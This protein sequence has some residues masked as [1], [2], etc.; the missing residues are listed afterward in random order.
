MTPPLDTASPSSRHAEAEPDILASMREDLTDWR[1]WM[2]RAVVLLYAVLAGLAVVLFTWVSDGA[3]DG[4]DH[5]RRWSPWAPLVW[6][7]CCTALLVWLTRRFAPGAAG[8]GI[9]QVMAA[10]A[11][12]VT[13]EHRGLFVSLRLSAEKLLLVSGGLLGGL[14]IGR[15]GPSVQIAAG[16]MQHAQR[17][18]PQRSPLHH[19]GLLVAGGAAGIAAAFNAPL[20]GVMFAIE[21]M[22]RK[23]E[24]RTSG[25]LIA[26]IVLAG[27]VAVSVF[28]NASYFGRLRVEPLTWAHLWPGLLTA[29]AC[30]LMGGVFSRLLQ[31]SLLGG[32]DRFSR[33]RARYPVRFAFACGLVIAVMGWVS[34]GATDGSGYSYTRRLVEGELDLPVL[35]V[36]LRIVATWLAVWSGV[37]GGIFAPSLAIGAGIGSDIA[38]LAGPDQ[39]AAVMIAIGMTAFLAAVTQAPITAFIIV[40]EMVD[41]HAMVLSLMAAALL[42][43]LMSRWISVPIYHR[44]AQAQLRRLPD[45][46][47]PTPGAAATSASS[48][49]TN[50]S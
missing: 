26:A 32:Q 13:P 36:T 30:G 29:V 49:A 31:R 16:V 19:D 33:W 35:Y 46:P 18:L 43:S 25:L 24:Q 28:G 50:A 10:L 3:I 12:Q 22:T 38:Q 27:L 42:A 37:P 45:Q 23:I 40:M 5:L 14:A 17:W 4:F 34:H 15:E 47:A 2:A 39:G 44:L 41:G 9:P 20:A 7:P 11:P 6:T 8:S 21:E 1:Q 48:S